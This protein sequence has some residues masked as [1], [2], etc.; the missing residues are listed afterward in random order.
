MSAQH[1]VRGSATRRRIVDAA[2]GLMYE[3]GVARTSLDDVRAATATSKSQ[4]YHY[5]RDKDDLV[6]AVI[7]AQSSAV[8]GYHERLLADASTLADLRAWADSLVAHQRENVGVGGCPIGSLSSELADSHEPAR[9]ALAATFARWESL[10]RAALTTMRARGAIAPTADPSAL[11]GAI[12]TALEGG[13]LLTQA[14][15][16]TRHLELALDMAL[17]NVHEDLGS[18]L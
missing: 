4:L 8:L 18:G 5:F 10:L 17:R 7:D 11:A 13:L 12:V 9:R 14:T 2:A 16:A 1:T 6:L 15:R 3:R